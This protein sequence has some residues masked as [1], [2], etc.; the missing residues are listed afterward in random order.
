[1]SRTLTD[2]ALHALVDG[3][4]SPA[5]ARALE[6]RLASYPELAARTAR[7]RRDREALKAAFEPILNEPLPAAFARPPDARPQLFV[8]AAIGF[9]AGAILA[10]M[11]AWLIL[12]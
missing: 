9:L 1:M 5:N 4:L 11:G 3:E 8:A 2:D 7:W 12:Q 6:E 10:G